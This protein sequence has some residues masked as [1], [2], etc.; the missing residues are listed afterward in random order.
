[1]N[2]QANKNGKHLE[3][4]IDNDITLAEQSYRFEKGI[5]DF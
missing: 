1:M 3:K 2:F 5:L 4:K